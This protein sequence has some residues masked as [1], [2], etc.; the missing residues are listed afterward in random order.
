M[1]KKLFSFLL[2]FVCAGLLYAEGLPQTSTEGNEVWYL[3]Q[4]SN[5]GSV[6]NAASNNANITTGSMDGADSQWWKF[7]GD[8]TKGYTIT[9]KLG[10]TLCSDNGNKET[11]VKA[12]SNPRGTSK[13][14]IVKTKHTNYPKAFEIEPSSNSSV[15]MNLFGGPGANHGVGYWDN[16]NPDPNNCV[17]FI[18]QR[19]YE[20]VAIIPY[21]ASLKELKE[22]GLDVKTLKAISCPNDSMAV[23][24][25]DFANQL[26]L[27]SGTELRVI[28]GEGQAEN[29]IQMTV[30]SK[31]DKEAY[32][33][34]VNDNGVSITASHFAGF[35]YALQ[36]LKQMLPNA[37]FEKQANNKVAWTLPFLDIKDKPQ[38]AHRGFMLDVARHFFDK[39]EIMHII[40]VMSLYK[41]NVFHWHL[42]EDQG[43]R[44][45]IPEYPKLTE[46]GSIRKGSF[47]LPADGDNGAFF[48]DTEYGRGM[49]YSQK[50]LKE[51]VAYAQARNINI[52]PEVDFPGHML[53]AI[54][55]YPELSCNPDKHYEVRIESGVSKDVLNIGN[56]KVIDFL[57]TIMDNLAQIFPSQYIHFGGDEC[58]T[59]QWRTNEECQQRIKDN[60]LK[61]VEEL[62][63]WLIEELG[64][65]VKEKYNRDIM[66]WDELVDHWNTKNTIKP[67]IMSWLGKSNK[68]ADMGLKS[69]ACPYNTTYLDMMQIDE[70]NELIDEPYRGGWGNNVNSVEKIYNFNP[71]YNLSG[72]EQFGYGVQ[73]NMWTETTNNDDELEYQLFPRLLAL[74]ETG[75]L[76]NSEKN[77]A[78][79]HKRLQSHD[80]ILDTYGI[81]YAKHYINPKKLTESEAALAEAE[82]ILNQ[83]IRGGV[84]YPEAKVYDT[85]ADAVKKAKADTTAIEE[86]K[87]ATA[88]YKKAPIVQ[89]QAG[90]MYQIISASTYSKKQFAGSSLYQAN[91]GLRIHYT[92]QA[93]PEELWEAVTTEGGYFLQN[94]GSKKQITLTAKNKQ[95]TLDEKGTAVRVDKATKASGKYTYIPGVVTISA[96]TGYSPNVT[97]NVKRLVAQ[98]SGNV[99]VADD[100]ALCYPGTWKM[101]EVIDFNAQL[102]GLCKKGE[103]IIR[104]NDA[105]QI[106]SYTNEAIAYLKEQIMEPAQE[107][108]K[109]VV[110]E[111]MYLTYLDRYN[112]FLAM[113]RN[114]FINS[115]DE[116]SYYYIQN[117]YYTN[118]YAGANGNNAVV[119]KLNE[120]DPQFLWQVE[121]NTD[122]TVSFKNKK[123][124]MYAFVR[125]A[126]EQ[127]RLQFVTKK[128]NATWIPEFVETDQNRSGIAITDKTNTLSWYIMVNGDIS[129]TNIVFRPKNYGA[130]IW[131]FIKT[132]HKVTG[133]ED[134]TVESQGKVTYYDLSGRKVNYPVNGLYIK[135]NGEKVLFR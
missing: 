56:D 16:G 106:G 110:T 97:G 81:N 107:A 34:K 58:P 43:W 130:S 101:I 11:M 105:N 41:L 28:K 99:N 38:L 12:S 82:D 29:A 131:N 123:N 74:S 47:T 91:S 111:E 22:G 8:A 60:N 120:K 112:K 42:T 125:K 46:I 109:G 132:D 126:T 2:A 116:N 73:G 93:E 31:L 135:S 70:N 27:V 1:I 79:F 25:Q 20:S 14:K 128:D 76:P 102:K 69:I 118:Y 57:K 75:W 122:G 54:S 21:P 129:S 65:Y 4:F 113:P 124:N 49:W 84:G 85:L 52:I 30:D 50:D 62:Q 103:S 53:A 51:V 90:K 88:D 66:V 40:D 33:L 83:S 115:I 134:L 35:F 89:P 78:L 72:K 19:E 48:D 121:K 63:S 55:A 71:Y 9:N 64:T 68:A 98:S 92:P 24:L 80:E 104:K 95:A 67:I 37:Y 133:I 100:A 39:N 114:S 18:S 36:T 87:K 61:G 3:I 77:W 23:H 117:A 94:V 17:I 15:S 45:E 6:F 26:K 13:F 32:T 44:I 7:E 96:V 5:G 86:L 10:Y 108:L 127:S 119:R 59:D